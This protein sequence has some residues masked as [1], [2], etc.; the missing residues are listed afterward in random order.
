[1]YGDAV[2]NRLAIGGKVQAGGIR[3]DGVGWVTMAMR[4]YSDEEKAAV[5]AA[6]MAGQSI[7]QVAEQYNIPTGTI[8]NWSAAKAHMGQVLEGQKRAIGEL[9]LECLR[10]ELAM[11][12]A[13]SKVMMDATWIQK[14]S[15]SELGVARG[16]SFDKAIRLLEAL[17]RQQEA[18]DVP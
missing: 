16:I 15:A 7:S 9:V 3:A 17:G 5:M 4:R 14:Q 2:R 10:S 8:S 12:I 1:M 13:Q 18:T 11:L 6:L